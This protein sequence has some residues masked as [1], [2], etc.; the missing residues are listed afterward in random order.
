MA[1]VSCSHDDSAV[2]IIERGCEAKM[3]YMTVQK[4]KIF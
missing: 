1:H 2:T 4:N 3:R